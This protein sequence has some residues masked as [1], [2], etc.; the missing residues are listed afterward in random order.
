MDDAFSARLRAALLDLL[1]CPT[2]GNRRWTM[3]RIAGA[4][5]IPEA[6]I[7]GFMNGGSLRLRTVDRLLIWLDANG[8]RVEP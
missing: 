5:G 8:V 4:S 3:R 7:R 6:T 1:V 2:C